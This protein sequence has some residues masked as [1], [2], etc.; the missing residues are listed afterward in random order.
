MPSP[1][2]QHE[3]LAFF[4]FK[5]GNLKLIEFPRQIHLEDRQSAKKSDEAKY[6]EALE[7]A[8][9]EVRGH[10]EASIEELK[11]RHKLELQEGGTPNQI[12][13]LEDDRLQLKS[14]AVIQ[15]H[16]ESIN[17]AKN[18]TE[19]ESRRHSLLLQRDCEEAERAHGREIERL[20]EDFERS[21]REK[22]ERHRSKIREFQDRDNAWQQEK[23]VRRSSS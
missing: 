4:F 19:S 17:N 9:R 3:S 18:L 20:R 5:S 23:Q 2:I 12:L 7:A 13:A 1:S 14:V 6:R 21:M 15:R 16:T 8:R 22:E 11:E 10:F